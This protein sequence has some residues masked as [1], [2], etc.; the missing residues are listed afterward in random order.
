MDGA[1][2]DEGAVFVS[3]GVEAAAVHRQAGESDDGRQGPN[4][5]TELV[6]KAVAS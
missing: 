1:V 5:V 2:D 4:E 3:R 6:K